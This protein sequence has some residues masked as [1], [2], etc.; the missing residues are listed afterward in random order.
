MECIIKEIVPNAVILSAKEVP[1]TAPILR[2]LY[3]P[4]TSVYTRPAKGE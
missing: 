3:S 1:L 4:A 2:K